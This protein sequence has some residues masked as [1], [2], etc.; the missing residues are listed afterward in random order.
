MDSLPIIICIYFVSFS[1]DHEMSLVFFWSVSTFIEDVFRNTT[2]NKFY[3]LLIIY[4][5]MW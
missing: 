5:I 4:Y 1:S 3:K 2:N